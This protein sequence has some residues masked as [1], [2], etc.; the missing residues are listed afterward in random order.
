MDLQTGHFEDR[1]HAR[2]IL[3]LLLF[4]YCEVFL[5][6]F[7]NTLIMN[8]QQGTIAFWLKKILDHLVKGVL[9]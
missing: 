2:I 5:Y 6:F 9:L 1:D 3:L 4:I 7:P 8:F